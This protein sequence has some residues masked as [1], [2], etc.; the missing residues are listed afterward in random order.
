MLYEDC[1]MGMDCSSL[2]ELTLCEKVG[3]KEEDI[4]FPSNNTPFEAYRKAFELRAVINLDDFSQIDNLKKALG[5][6]M[7]REVA[8]QFNPGPHHNIKNNR[9]ISNPAEEKFGL[10]KAQLFSAY[11]KYKEYGV[12]RFGLDTMVVSN[13]LNVL[14][15]AET[16]RMMFSLGETGVS[17]EFV[18]LGGIIGPGGRGWGIGVNYRP[19][20]MPG[21]LG[22][23]GL[24][25]KRLYEQIV[26]SHSDLHLLQIN[27]ECGG[28]VTGDCGWLVSRVINMKDT[29]KRFLG[30]VLP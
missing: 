12:K 3:I 18:T 27:Y 14:D 4:M 22:D 15:L 2:A 19:E 23:L 17:V 16:A 29:Y 28:V 6:D 9:Y 24:R 30:V 13:S 11:K 5:G 25:V 10:T 20:E 7:P 8:F 21:D 1:G 26:L